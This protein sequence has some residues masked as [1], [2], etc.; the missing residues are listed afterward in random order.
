MGPIHRTPGILVASVALGLGACGGDDTS[1]PPSTSAPASTA[2]A[3]TEPPT[4]PPTSTDAPPTTAGATPGEVFRFDG[5]ASV[6]GWFV[7]NDTVMGGVSD[8]GVSWA[9][10]AL[11]FAGTI[12]LDY[13]GGFA[14]VRGP[15][16]GDGGE[17]PATAEVM[18]LTTVGD[19]KTYVVQLRTDRASFTQRFVAASGEATH[20]LPLSGFEAT[21]FMLEPVTTEERLLPADIRGITIYILDKQEGPFELRVRSIAFA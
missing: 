6:A 14:S 13:N 17:V 4:T 21:D 3:T 19:G 11:V 12:S 18:S 7:Q 16:F 15:R 1:S 20:V 5:P 2:A 8:S 10:D 9:D